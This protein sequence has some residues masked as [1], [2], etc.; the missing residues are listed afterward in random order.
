MSTTGPDL[1]KLIDQEHG[2]VYRS[3]YS[4]PAIY[5]LE[6]EHIFARCWLCR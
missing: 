6:L 2:L 5:D 4:D 3:L 1:S